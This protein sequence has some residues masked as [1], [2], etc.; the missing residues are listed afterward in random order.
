MLQKI[1]VFV[2]LSFLV[3]QV[4]AQYNKEIKLVKTKINDKI[5]VSIPNDFSIMPEDAYARKYGA[6]RKPLAMYN[7]SNGYV[8]FGI[9][10]AVN[11]S[12]RS[13]ASSE[14][15]EEDLNIL[16]G[17]YKS[18]IAGMHAEV[19]F[20]QDKIETINKHKFIIL[21]FI[22]TVKDEEKNLI[23]GN[24]ELKQYSYIQYAV[25]DATIVI[26]NFTCPAKFKPQWQDVAKEMMQSIKLG[27]NL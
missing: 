27:K 11:R 23:S 20:I 6:Y 22:G 18:S 8:D 13:V 1:S 26:F 3:L 2:F 15:K 16:K 19:Q 17:I 25:E 24:K 12:M 5:T 10:T 7:S 14:W 4:Q 9:N 21:E